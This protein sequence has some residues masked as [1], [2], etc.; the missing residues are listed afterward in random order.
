L[1]DVLAEKGV[2]ATGRVLE[3][4][5]GTGTL[6]R[7]FAK[8]GWKCSGVD[9]SPAAIRMARQLSK[10]FTISYHVAD[11]VDLSLFKSKAFDL[12]LD[13]FC[14]HC[15]IRGSDREK[16]IGNIAQFLRPGGVA[17]INTM[18]GPIHRKSFK[19]KYGLIK[20]G[21]IYSQV[22]KTV[23]Y[24]DILCENGHYYIPTRRLEHWKDILISLKFHHLYPILF[25]VNICSELEPISYLSVVAKKS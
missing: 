8:R 1:D 12:V 6:T 21:I 7:W 13:G 5:C 17:I 23:D 16:Y 4:G 10:P 11:A 19:Q 18:A 15:L 25:K 20:K 3:I 14:L 22:E 2:P 9:I 24:E